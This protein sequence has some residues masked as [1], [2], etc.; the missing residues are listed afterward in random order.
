[1][2]LV[3]DKPMAVRSIGVAM[4]KHVRI[5]LGEVLVLVGDLVRIMRWPSTPGRYQAKGC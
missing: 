1:M 4:F 3:N 2:E 5:I